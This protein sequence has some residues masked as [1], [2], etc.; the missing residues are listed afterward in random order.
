[1]TQQGELSR[2]FSHSNLSRSWDLSA[3]LTHAHTV[4]PV[5]STNTTVKSVPLEIELSSSPKQSRAK[6]CKRR[7]QDGQAI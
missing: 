7:K 1:M 3:D 5:A 4:G 6:E 2:L